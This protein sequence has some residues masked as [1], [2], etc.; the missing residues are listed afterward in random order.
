MKGYKQVTIYLLTIGL[1]AGVSVFVGCTPEQRASMEKLFKTD[2]TRFLDPSRPIKAPEYA[3]LMPIL[4]TVGVVDSSQVIFPNATRPTAEDMSYDAADYV[5]GPG[6]VMDIG[7]IDLYADGDEAVLR[8]QVSDSGF[9]AMPM[10]D[11]EI[12]AEGLTQ[13]QLK[14]AIVNAYSPEILQSPEVS[15]SILSASQST[16]S[17]LGAIARPHV[18]NVTG[19]DMR[20]FEA[21]ALAGGVTQVNI[22]YIYIFRQLPPTRLD[23]EEAT[24]EKGADIKALDELPELP[25]LPDETPSKEVEKNDNL[26]ELEEILGPESE[27]EP[28]EPESE[29]EDENGPIS[30]YMLSETSSVAGLG[31]TTS[32]L[33]KAKAYKWIYSNGRWVRVAQEAGVADKPSGE[34]APPVRPAGEDL[35]SKQTFEGATRRVV[36]PK[37]TPKQPAG[38]EDDPFGWKHADKSNLGRIIAIDLRNLDRGDPRMNI[39]IR[40]KDVILVPLLEVGEFYVTGEVPRPGVYSL[41]GR[42]ITLKQALA[43]AGGPGPLAWLPNTILIRRIGDNQ[44][45]TIPVDLEAVLRGEEPDY[46]LK[47]NDVL[48]IG[49]DFRAPFMAVVRNAFR[50]TYGFGFIYDRNFADPYLETLNNKRFTRW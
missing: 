29:P 9:I 27:E 24:T 14:D 44:E 5:M 23:E 4:P 6:D 21:I 11:K 43:A 32:T 49:S 42:N 13:Q 39:V 10:I 40:D 15:V 25:E 50:M 7:I 3:S 17:I 38:D 41:T 48:A 19:N 28:A 47:P 22:R 20:L 30:I 33:P 8:R 12:K 35:K 26:K 31:S 18:Y 34:G 1:M 37:A 36:E 2:R 45:L 16:F 46:M